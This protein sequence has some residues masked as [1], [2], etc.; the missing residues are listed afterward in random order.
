LALSKVEFKILVSLGL[1][2]NFKV[3]SLAM[4]KYKKVNIAFTYYLK[5]NFNYPKRLYFFELNVYGVSLS[6]IT[7]DFGQFL[8]SFT[9]ET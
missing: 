5:I 2:E 7:H 1:I 6:K 9:D 4:A 8:G 3:L